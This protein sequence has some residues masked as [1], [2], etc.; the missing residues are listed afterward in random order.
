[1]NTADNSNGQVIERIVKNKD[2]YFTEPELKE[3]L[4]ELKASQDGLCAIT[5]I[6]MQWDGEADDPQLLCSLDRIDSSGH[7]ERGNLQLLC[8]F[9][10]F[11][12]NNSLDKEFRRLIDIVRTQA[13]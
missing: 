10:N 3:Y 5:G 8:R 4:E 6:P 1:M 12:K 13:L 2:A 11:W 7:Y 9:V